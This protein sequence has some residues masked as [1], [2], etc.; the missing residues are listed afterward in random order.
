MEVPYLLIVCFFLKVR[1]MKIIKINHEW[2]AHPSYFCGGLN[3]VI[4]ELFHKMSL[5]KK[6]LSVT[7]VYN[8]FSKNKCHDQKLAV[9]S[10]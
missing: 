1:Q 8:I 2:C 7:Y 3:C 9:S 5:L 10:L 6:N 4:N